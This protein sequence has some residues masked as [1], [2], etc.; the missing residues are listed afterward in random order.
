MNQSEIMSAAFQE[1]SIVAAATQQT[2]KNDI[3]MREAGYYNSN[4]GL[5]FAAML[6]ALPLFEDESFAGRHG[7]VRLIEYGSAQ[8]SNS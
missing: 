8:G 2:I 7:Q 5:Q 6:E 1:E 3:P 4:S